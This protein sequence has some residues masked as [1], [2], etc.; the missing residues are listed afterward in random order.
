MSV[1]QTAYWYCPPTC[2]RRFT[3]KLILTLRSNVPL[4]MRTSTGVTKRDQHGYYSGANVRTASG[5]NWTQH[6]HSSPNHFHLHV[7]RNKVTSHSVAVRHHRKHMGL[8]HTDADE[9]VSPP[10]TRAQVLPVAPCTTVRM[11]SV[12]RGG[13]FV[14][15]AVNHLPNGGQRGPQYCENQ[16]H[17]YGNQST[18]KSGCA[19]RFRGVHLDQ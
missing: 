4:G 12:G 15:G 14:V 8:E 17:V 10:S 18:A 16:Q 1:A 3:L 9:I 11:V 13:L 5:L 6:P 2:R 19:V 7:P